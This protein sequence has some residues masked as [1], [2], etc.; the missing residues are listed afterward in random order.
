VA[1][2]HHERWDGGGYP[3]GISGSAIPVAARMVAIC[4]VYDSLTHTKPYRVAW[5]CERALSEILA[6]KDTQFDPVLVELFVPMLR[7]LRTEYADL[8]AYLGAAAQHSSITQARRK[9][10]ESLARPLES[11]R[12]ALRAPTSTAPATSGI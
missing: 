11:P 12:A 2:H 5:D 7:R 10:A 9:I 8:D 6:H 3:E 4:D 1:R